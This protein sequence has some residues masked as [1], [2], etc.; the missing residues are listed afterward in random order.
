MR[1][2]AGKNKGIKL[3]TLEGMNTRPTLDR[4][5]ESVFNMI[6]NFM[7]IEDIENVL[8][9]FSGSGA[10]AL[11]C[12]SRYNSKVIMVENNIDASKIIKE[13]VNKIKAENNSEI[14]LEDAKNY[15]EKVKNV[16]KFNLIF[17]DP[18]YKID[19]KDIIHKILEYNLLDEV[20]T[21]SLW[22]R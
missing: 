22:N 13:N 1:I 18:P 4:V 2:I 16:K 14:V 3:N 8:D 11:E 7:Y 10:L 12:I 20:R 9:L 21:N 5:K 17:L 6:E 19:T 15:L